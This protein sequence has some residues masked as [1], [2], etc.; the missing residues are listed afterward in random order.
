MCL[1]SSLISAILTARIIINY[2]IWSLRKKIKMPG[3]I[4][5]LFLIWY[6]FTRFF[7]DHLRDFDLRIKLRL[8]T[9]LFLLTIK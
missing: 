6:S 3:I 7:I 9:Q 8:S 1:N 2:V 5:S 4:F